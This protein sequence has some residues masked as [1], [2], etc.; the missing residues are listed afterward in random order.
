MRLFKI[1]QFKT[2]ERFLNTFNDTIAFILNIDDYTASVCVC[3]EVL[4]ILY[5]RIN[6]IRPTLNE[7]ILIIT[8]L[9]DVHE[10]EKSRIYLKY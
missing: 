9:K 4:N 5:Y 7:L 2:D 8:E 1:V 3:V 10:K 6:N